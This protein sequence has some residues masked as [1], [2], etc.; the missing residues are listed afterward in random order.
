[1]EVFVHRRVDPKRVF[2]TKSDCDPIAVRHQLISNIR[3]RLSDLGSGVYVEY[4]AMFF[5]LHRDN[6][7][8]PSIVFNNWDMPW[9][10]RERKL[11]HIKNIC[12]EPQLGWLFQ[13]QSDIVNGDKDFRLQLWKGSQLEENGEI[14][15]HSKK[16]KQ[17]K[18]DF[19][20]HW[21]M[22][23]SQLWQ[24]TAI[25]RC[26]VDEKRIQSLC[27]RAEECLTPQECQLKGRITA[28][29]AISSSSQPI[30]F[31]V[32][33]FSVWRS[34]QIIFA[35]CAIAHRGNGSRK[36]FWLSTIAADLCCASCSSR[37]MESWSNAE[38]SKKKFPK[39][40]VFRP[41]LSFQKIHFP[42][43]KSQFS[44]ILFLSRGS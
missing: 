23:L 29:G 26:S 13:C 34:L 33:I 10:S 3:E 18:P 2:V 15:V 4:A 11:D 31:S 38:A 43:K 39:K 5:E 6:D 12:R 40:Q 44:W 1:M 19:S 24:Q 32:A 37:A 17:D 22:K 7:W 25:R 27:H 9:K 16:R 35:P 8:L 41:G 28:E 14:L 42:K 21:S 20:V 36:W 30:L